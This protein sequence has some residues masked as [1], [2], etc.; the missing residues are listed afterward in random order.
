MFSVQREGILGFFE[1]FFSP[2]VRKQASHLS[3]TVTALL[4]H[5]P[6]KELLSIFPQNL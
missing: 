4:Q 2:G 6:E 1:Y 3:F 5:Y